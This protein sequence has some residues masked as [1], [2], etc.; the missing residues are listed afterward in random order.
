MNPVERVE[1]ETERSGNGSN[2]RIGTIA[3]FARAALSIRHTAPGRVLYRL[4]PRTLVDLLK[5]R[6]PS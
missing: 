2:T 6:L 1:P 5:A 4:A 3:R